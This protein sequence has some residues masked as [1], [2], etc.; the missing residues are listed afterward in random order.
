MQDP[1]PNEGE[2]LMPIV[3]N[4]GVGGTQFS[5]ENEDGEEAAVD[6]VPESIETKSADEGEEGE[7]TE[8]I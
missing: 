7:G 8:T 3:I 6:L 4:R 5:S 1:N 2:T